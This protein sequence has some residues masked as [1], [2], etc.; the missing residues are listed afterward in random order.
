MPLRLQD[1]ER[2]HL[3]LLAAAVCAAWLSRWLA[4]LSVLLGGAVMG[5]NFWLLRQLATRMLTATP[6]RPAVVLGLVLIKFSLFIGLVALLIVRVRLDPM[7]FGFGASI[8]LVACVVA[9]L[10][11]PRAEP[12]AA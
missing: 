8:L 11:A 12:L 1:I 2:L 6:R 10:R 9:A 3:W 7:A 5:G 4:P